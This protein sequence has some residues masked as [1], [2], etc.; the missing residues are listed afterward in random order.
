[1]TFAGIEIDATFIALVAFCLFFVV[2]LYLKVPA[3]V[4]NM[5]DQRSQAIAKELH[6]A[7]RLR[8]QAEALLAEYKAKH[9][10]ADAEAKTIVAHA[11]EQAEALVQEIRTQMSAAIAR[12]QRQAEDRITQAQAKAEADVRAAAAEAALAAAERMLRERLDANAQADLVSQGV[13][14]MQTRKFG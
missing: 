12:R 10:A 6:E 5:L 14:E 1:M 4:M 9:A 8:E 3:M 2:L 7:R 11:Q 13:S